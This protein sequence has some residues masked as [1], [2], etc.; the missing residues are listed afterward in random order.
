MKH[1]GGPP[2]STRDARRSVS[3]GGFPKA[4]FGLRLESAER[5]EAVLARDRGDRTAVLSGVRQR[6]PRPL[7]P[8]RSQ[9][10]HWR[11][12]A[13]A[14][15]ASC[16]ALALTPAARATSVSPTAFATFSSRKRSARLTEAGAI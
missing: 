10:R 6:A 12:V 11:R 15:D 14:V 3:D 13:E 7:E 1:Q 4:G 9:L 16:N 8:Q 2:I 5:A